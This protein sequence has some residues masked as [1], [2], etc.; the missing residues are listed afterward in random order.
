MRD[1]GYLLMEIFL[2]Q[3]VPDLHYYLLHFLRHFHQVENDGDLFRIF[4]MAVFFNFL[5]F[6]IPEVILSTMTSIPRPS[7]NGV[8]AFLNSLDIACAFFGNLLLSILLISAYSF[9]IL[10]KG[11]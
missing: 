5:F 11:W 9:Q 2:Y 8:F 10:D 6:P 7:N 1:F 3:W 4:T